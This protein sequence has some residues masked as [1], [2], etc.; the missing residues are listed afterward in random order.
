[1][2]VILDHDR[3]TADVY[4]FDGFHPRIGWNSAEAKA[5]YRGSYTYG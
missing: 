4:E 5:G 3:K 2:T 1:M